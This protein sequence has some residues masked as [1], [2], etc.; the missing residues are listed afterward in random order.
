MSLLLRSCTADHL[1]FINVN[2]VYYCLR[3]GLT[4]MALKAAEKAVDVAHV[5]G[6]SAAG[7]G[8]AAGSLR[9]LLEQW[10]EDR[11]AFRQAHGAAMLRECERLLQGYNMKQVGGQ[12]ESNSSTLATYL[13]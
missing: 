3:C 1:C 13:I 4:D 9:P 7:G 6:S 2:Q 11:N 12:S 5:R 10:L 8:G